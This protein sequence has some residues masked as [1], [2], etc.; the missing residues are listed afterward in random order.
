MQ[1]YTDVEDWAKSNLY[2]GEFCRYKNKLYVRHHH[3]DVTVIFYKNIS[4]LEER[5][6]KLVVE[7]GFAE[8]K[9]P[10]LEINPTN[11]NP[12]GNDMTL[13]TWTL[14]DTNFYGTQLAIN[15]SGQWV[16]EVKGTGEVV[17]VDPSIVEE[18]IPHTVD[19][20]FLG[21]NINKY[22]YWAP[23]GKYA[24]NDVL[25]VKAPSGLALVL[26]TK[27]DT[28]SKEATKDLP[29]VGKIALDTAVTN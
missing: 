14:N 11:N 23:A 18:V 9:V 21:N 8:V 29:V 16:M 2:S 19:V 17:A 12:K 28:K 4:K 3:N 6:R 24:V 1:K 7:Q 25:L 13:Y 22:S 5:A 20:Q 10:L 27:V 15:S 26:V